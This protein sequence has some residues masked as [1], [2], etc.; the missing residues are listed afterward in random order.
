MPLSRVEVEPDIDGVLDE[1]FWDAASV[2]DDLVQVV[3]SEGAAPSERTEIRVVYTSRAMFLGVRCFDRDPSAIIATQMVRDGQF[4]SDDRIEMV[5]DTNRDRRNAFFFTVNAVGARGDGLVTNNDRLNREWDGHWSARVVTDGEGWTAEIRIPYTTISFEEG[6]EVWGFNLQRIIR[7]RNETVRWAGIRQDINLFGSIAE[8]GDLEGIIEISQG[9]GLDVRPS[10]SL[11]YRHD[12][13]GND[14]V[15]TWDPSLDVFY[16]LTPELTAVFTANTDFAE[17][18]VDERRVNLTRFPLFFPEKRDFFLQDA[19]IFDFGGVRRSPR[20]FFSRR[21]G[22]SASGEPVDI[23]AGIKV[24]GRID[25]FNVGVLS[26][27]QAEADGVES[28]NLAVAR[29]SYNILDESSVGIIATAGDPRSNDDNYLF[30]GDFNIRDRRLLNGKTLEF[31]G[32]AM[33]SFTSGID[34][35]EWSFGARVE[36]PND[37]IDAA[38]GF[39][40]IQENYNPAL[41]FVTRRGI[42][43]YFSNFRY[44]W[45]F[46]EGF[47]RTIDTGVFFFLADRLEGGVESGSFSWDIV[48]LRSADGDSLEL[49]YRRRFEGLDEPFEISDGV[50]VPVGNY[51]SDRYSIEFDS[52]RARTV[53]GGF[54]VSWGEFLSGTRLEVGGF[55][56]V[57]PSRHL[58]VGLEYE[59]NDIRLPEGNFTTRVARAR[60]NVF[61]TP[62]ISWRTFAQYDNVSESLGINSRFRWILEDDRELFVVINQAFQVESYDFRSTVS[63]LAVKITWS[64]RF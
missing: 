60:V 1:S 44:R 9:L 45:R 37:D 58:T 64:I 43:E 46:E 49:T 14:D 51:H 12:R 25:D 22:R 6:G 19:G 42:D 59:Q 62:D 47:I 41:G 7:R 52:S 61:F 36:Y 35:K 55:F 18:E 38:I 26:V 10:L 3:P 17:A 28:K 33:K 34:D 4:G 40:Q 13:P 32:F 5:L 23:L 31:K 30:G 21:I 2:I 16:K 11:Q 57:R 27:Q 20:A 50:V 39:T 48:R 8:A 63:E 54:E 56:E 29:A 53:S 15:F 24:T